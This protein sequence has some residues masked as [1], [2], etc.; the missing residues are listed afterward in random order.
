MKATVRVPHPR[1]ARAAVAPLPAG[2]ALLSKRNENRFPT[3]WC[4]D[5]TE[6]AGIPKTVAVGFSS[7]CVIGADKNKRVGFSEQIS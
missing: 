6:A 4:G 7:N 3:P 5:G 2:S 1:Q